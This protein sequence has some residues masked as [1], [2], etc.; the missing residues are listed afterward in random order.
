MRSVP[1]YVCGARIIRV[2]DDRSLVVSDHRYLRITARVEWSDLVSNAE[3]R[4]QK[5]GAGSQTSLF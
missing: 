5:L 4:Y 1:L 3:V 2:G